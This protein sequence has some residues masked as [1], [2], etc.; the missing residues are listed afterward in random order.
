M[1]TRDTYRSVT[2]RVVTRTTAS[3][4][5]LKM[6]RLIYNTQKVLHTFLKVLKVFKR[7]SIKGSRPK[8]LAN[9]HK[10]SI[11]YVIYAP[12]Q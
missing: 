2:P 7:F 10:T 3:G 6:T 1:K 4:S 5:L 11:K 12:L 9:K 8:F